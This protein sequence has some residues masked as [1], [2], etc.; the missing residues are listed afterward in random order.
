MSVL[1]YFIY[2]CYIK[3]CNTIYAFYGHKEF[4]PQIISYY[5]IFALPL[6]LLL[7]KVFLG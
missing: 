7:Q 5:F 4:K 2:S 1:H 6:H 3:S